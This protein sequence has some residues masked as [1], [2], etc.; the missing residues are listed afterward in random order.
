MSN[1]TDT[2]IKKSVHRGIAWVSLA[3]SLVGVLDIVATVLIVGL[4]LTKEQ[5]GVALLAISVFPVL[6]IATDLGLAAAV[7]QRDDHSKS[8]ISTV[9]WLNVAMSLTLFLLLAVGI[10]PLI[11]HIQG[12][13]VVAGLLTA[14][15]AKLVWQNVYFLPYALMKRELRF[16]ELS[17]IRIIANFAEFAGKVGAAAGG[18]GIWCFIVGPLCRV[19]VTGVGVQLRHPWRPSFVFVWSEGWDWAKFGLK[20]SAHKILFRLY[21]VIDKQVVGFYFSD[22]ALAVYGIAYLVVLEPALVISEI[23]VNVA[24]PTFAKLKHSTEKLYEQLVSFCKMNLVVM[25][26]FIG[27]IFVGAEE[28]LSIFDMRKGADVTADY[29]TGAPI[30][31]L[32][33]GIAVLRALSFV[34]PPFLD[35]VGRPTLTLLYTSVAAVALTVFFFVFANL[36]G[37]EMGAS[38]VALGWLAGY[39]IAFAV[40]IWL[41][42]SILEMPSYKLYAR[43]SGIAACGLVAT[44]CTGGVKYLLMD[45]PTVARFGALVATMILT[46]GVLLSRFLGINIRAVKSSLAADS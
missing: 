21:S 36:L 20:T 19:F 37:D 28:I 38:S 15:G 25:L 41:A 26:L 46:Y 35:G 10:G 23:I 12:K 32:L 7:I 16:K 1:E 42:F 13:D 5:F 43:L 22:E 9:F 3:S 44:L 27:I 39:P 30:I 29:T 31:R 40:L 45:L 33:C 8:R 6:D 11:A 17:V 14:Y 18:L 2:N 24:F 34:I 4:W